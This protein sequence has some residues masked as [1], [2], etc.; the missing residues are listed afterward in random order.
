MIL[1]WRTVSL[2]GVAFSSSLTDAEIG[3]LSE[4]AEG[5][6]ALEVG[7]A[8]GYAACSMA[9]GGARHV[10]TVDPHE[11]IPGS[12]GVLASNVRELALQHRVTPTIGRSQHVLAWLLDHGL[13][14]DLVFIDGDHRRERVEQ[15]LD[16]AWRLLKPGGVLAAHDYGEETCPGVKAATDQFA[17]GRHLR[18]QVIDTLWIARRAL[19]IACRA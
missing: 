2:R 7:S 11:A 6:E 1:P 18:G 4:L 15:D 8:Y 14:F 19:W 5:R 17:A 12:L 3:R 13:Q 10:L 9:T 16:L